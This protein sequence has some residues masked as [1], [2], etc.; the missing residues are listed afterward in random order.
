M[1]RFGEWKKFKQA[2][3][4]THIDLTQQG[5]IH[6]DKLRGGAKVVYLWNKYKRV[7]AIAAS[8]AGVTAIGISVL[9]NSLT[10]HSKDPKV[11]ELVHTVNAVEKNQKFW[12]I[13]SIMLIRKINNRLFHA[14][15]FQWNRF[16]N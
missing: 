16:F 7:T 10:P 2:L 4:E 13:R 12:I 14:C 9:V 3:H 5:K 6:S 1:N 11:L 8:I 15:A